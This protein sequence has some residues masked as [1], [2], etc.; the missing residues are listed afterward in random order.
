LSLSFW[1]AL[2][3]S[4]RTAAQIHAAYGDLSRAEAFDS[5]GDAVLEARGAGEGAAA[6]ERRLDQ[7]SE[8]FPGRND[9]D[10]A[11]TA[12]ANLRLSLVAPDVL[13]PLGMGG[14]LSSISRWLVEHYP[15][16]AG[17]SIAAAGALYG[18]SYALFYADLGTSPARAGLTISQIVGASVSGGLAL[19]AVLIPC[20]FLTFLPLAVL[21]DEPEP[22]HPRRSWPWAFV[23]LAL[24][25]PSAVGIWVLDQ[26]LD[27]RSGPIGAI[28]SAVVAWIAFGFLGAMSGD[29]MQWR[30][31]A[32][33]FKLDQFGAFVITLVPLALILAGVATVIESDH[34]GDEARRGRAVDNPHLLG[35]PFIGLRAEPATVRWV[36]RG[37]STPLPR[38]LLYLGNT[39]GQAV[40][41]AARTKGTVR[42]P[43]N[44]VELRV[45]RSAN[46][47][48]R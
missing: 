8:D 17:L 45:G 7:W 47:C 13:R 38:C 36:R 27:G 18:L 9:L 46:D 10:N 32:L 39:G 5:V 43:S 3:A 14:I 2:H 29:P 22:G 42:L 34:L 11:A 30:L 40:L 19:T 12:I 48:A 21:D 23:Y 33:T 41:Y 31:P 16:V 15:A 4:E 20:L 44:A 37:S 25:V 6:I 24:I 26:S 28:T 35:V 1:T